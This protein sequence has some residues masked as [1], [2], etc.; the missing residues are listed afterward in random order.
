[1]FLI[2]WLQN[3]GFRWIEALIVTLLGVI[4][5][6]FAIQIALANPDWAA[7]IRGFAPTTDIVRNP[8]ML[9]LGDRHHRRDRDAA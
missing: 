9:Y 2:L 7:V 6:C 1:M 3:L 4:A 5:V 8:D